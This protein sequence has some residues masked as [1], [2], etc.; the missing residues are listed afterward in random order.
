M[1]S[2]ND[3]PVFQTSRF[4]VSYA[5]QRSSVRLTPLFR[6]IIGNRLTLQI[7]LRSRDG[8][9]KKVCKIISII[10]Y[11][12][13]ADW[14]HNNNGYG[15]R[16]IPCDCDDE[17]SRFIDLWITASVTDRESITEAI[18]SGDANLFRAYSER[19]ASL[20]VRRC[21]SQI[22][23]NGLVSLSVDNWKFDSREYLM[24]AS[25]IYHSAEL[26]GQDPLALLGEIMEYLPPNAAKGFEEF[27]MRSPEGRDIRNMLYRESA[28]K[29]GFRYSWSGMF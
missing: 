23:I 21:S 25:I 22:I 19:M 26:I 17:I 1:D 2:P 24:V 6:A 15:R 9:E 8:K 29:D 16:R 4:V 20:A 13:D 7:T 14:R 12:T 3:V 5:A 11:F 28:D 27:C 18:T 10:D